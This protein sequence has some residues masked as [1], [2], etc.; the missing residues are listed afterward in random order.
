MPTALALWRPLGA[1]ALAGMALYW[2]SRG[3]STF[4]F[5][6]IAF[7]GQTAV[8]C[9]ILFKYRVLNPLYYSISFAL[10]Y[11]LSFIK[12]YWFLKIRGQ[13]QGAAPLGLRTSCRDDV[14]F[15][16]D[17]LPAL[18][19]LPGVE[20]GGMRLFRVPKVGNSTG[21]PSALQGA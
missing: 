12:N 4:D 19:R 15:V 7:H 17:V 1:N 13:K 14:A 16:G 8:F 5:T 6:R 20:I 10:D 3:S 11:N 21:N 2:C 9:V 18:Q